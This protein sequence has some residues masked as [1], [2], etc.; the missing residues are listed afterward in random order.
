M[1]GLHLNSS[2]IGSAKGRNARVTSGWRAARYALTISLA[3]MVSHVGAAGG[4]RTYEAA[5]GSLMITD[6]N[7]GDEGKSRDSRS[8][9]KCMIDGHETITDTPTSYRSCRVELE[10]R[11][12]SG[13]RFRDFGRNQSLYDEDIKR[14]AAQQGVPA[15]LVKAVMMA[16]SAFNPKALSPKN[17]QGLMQLIPS[18][19]KL[20]GVTDPWDAQQNIMGGTKYLKMMLDRFGGDQRL[21][22]AAYNAGPRNVDKHGGVPPFAETQ[23]YVERVEDL[24]ERFSALNLALQSGKGR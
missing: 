16:E 7:S 10:G 20:V 21:A 5:D 9:Y 14:V 22:I 3:L 6:G 18:T 19:A 1:N 23:A 8:Y 12:R 4:L 2:A 17:A 13:S 24:F 15:A 11:S